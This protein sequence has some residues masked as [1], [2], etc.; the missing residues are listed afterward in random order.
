[1]ECEIKLEGCP[2]QSVV[3]LG[4]SPLKFAR[5]R[6]YRGP[7][8]QCCLHCYRILTNGQAPKAEPKSTVVSSVRHRKHRVADDDERLGKLI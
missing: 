8:V 2:A 3:F 6:N 1:M 4:I 7:L 5:V